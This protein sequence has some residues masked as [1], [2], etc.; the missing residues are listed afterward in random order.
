MSGGS[1]DYIYSKIDEFAD[2]ISTLDTGC[3][4]SSASLRRAFKAHLHLVAKAARAIEWNDSGD[5]DDEECDL[6][7]QVCG[8][9]AEL[10]EAIK[11]A[12]EARSELDRAITAARKERT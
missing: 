12:S 7:R 2:A 10:T 9:G 3:G 1:Y 5:G 4:H 6:I 8:Q 11:M